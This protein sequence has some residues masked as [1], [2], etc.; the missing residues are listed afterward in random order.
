MTI[1]V[2]NLCA[3]SYSAKWSVSEAVV[4]NDME[5]IAFSPHSKQQSP[6][7]GCKIN[8]RITHGIGIESGISCKNMK[9]GHEHEID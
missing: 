6:D 3:Y 7:M 2:H 8:F 9:K 1:V 4:R 5:T